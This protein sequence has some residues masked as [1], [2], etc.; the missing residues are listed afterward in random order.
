MLKSSFTI[1]LYC[2]VFLSFSQETNKDLKIFL[3]CN[4]CDNT[5]IKQNLANV[6]F[7]RDQN[8][9][10][11]HLFFITQRNGSDGR[12]YEIEFIG[13]NA[14][15]KFQDTLSFSTNTD[16]TDD[17]IRQRILKYIKLGLVRFWVKQ[18]SV[19]N[20]SV[21][22]T[23]PEK[24]D[25]EKKEEKDPWNYWVFRIGVNGWF[26]GQETSKFSNI[27]FNVSAKRVT[28]KNKFSL[29]LGLRENKSTFSFE[30]DEIISIQSSKY[31]NTSD[32]ISIN[33]HWS[34]GA[35]ARL[36]T[37][38]F[39]NKDFYWSVRPA[40]E[41]NFFKYSESSKKQLTLS[42]RNGI[43]YNNYIERTI[44][45][46]EK[47]HLWEHELSLGG[48]VN[49]KWGS[50]SGEASY[51]QFLHDTTLNS[52]SF[53]VGTNVRLFKGFSLN[54]HGN[55]NITRNQIELPAGEVSLE[56]LLLQQQQ[57]KSGYNYFVSVGLSYSFG[58][59]YNTIVNP[60]FNF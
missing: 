3:D 1:F 25:E 42:Y 55:Y 13:R 10:D 40:V 17:D 27:N 29:R 2:F 14:F 31:V 22:V 16:M 52:L 30:D 54:L 57:L 59:I 28:E 41:Y 20:I 4:S 37:S 33:E 50:I 36:G 12:S 32:I 26:N 34:V 6:E 58:S 8:F 48:S 60:R 9:A 46:E 5:Y 47:E 49:Q 18:G 38:V 43:A 44:F 24:D 19:D 23:K 53:F 21:T 15:E 35:F 56:E 39:R 51:E 7:V 11:V 45:G